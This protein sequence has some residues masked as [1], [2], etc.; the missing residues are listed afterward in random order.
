MVAK[1]IN[2]NY[3]MIDPVLIKLDMSLFRGYRV[4]QPKTIPYLP[5]RTYCSLFIILQWFKHNYAFLKDFDM[6]SSVVTH[7]LRCHGYDPRQDLTAPILIFS[8]FSYFTEV[9]LEDIWATRFL[10]KL[11][12][13]VS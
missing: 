7:N 12:S 6:Q 11:C 2:P 1:P 10:I 9:V 4:K 8:N 5:A 3:P 13:L